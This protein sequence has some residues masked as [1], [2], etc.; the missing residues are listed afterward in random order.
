MRRRSPG[1]PL[2]PRRGLS[3]R[4]FTDVIAELRRAVWPSRREIVRLT[5]M[6]ISVAVAIGVFLG[7][8]D[9]GFTLLAKVLF[10]AR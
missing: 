2:A 1:R 7:A 8:V 5:L 10:P 9:Y 3:L 4:F 6:V